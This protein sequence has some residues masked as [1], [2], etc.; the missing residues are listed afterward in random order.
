MKIREQYKQI[1]SNNK[2]Q[3]QQVDN[4]N[5]KEGGIDTQFTKWSYS[6]EI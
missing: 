1:K 6:Y 5:N 3:N 2:K 4:R